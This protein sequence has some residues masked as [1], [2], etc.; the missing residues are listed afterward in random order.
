[1][2]HAEGRSAEAVDAMRAAADLE[3]TS[4]KSAISPGPL[5]PARELLGDML[6]A[7][8]RAA[9]ALEAYQASMAKEPNRFRGL[10][11]G[12]RA[13]ASAG[14][15]DLAGEYRRHL[16]EICVKGDTPGRAVL[17]AARQGH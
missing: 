15:A 17:V 1:V 7:A 6:M 12:M 14:R 10:S 13:A 2:A 16:V 9:E 8:G 11:G 5:V 4:E 3:D